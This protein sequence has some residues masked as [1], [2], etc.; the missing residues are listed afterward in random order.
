MTIWFTADL[1]LGHDNIIG[2]CNRPFKDVKEMNERLI[3]GWQSSVEEKDSIYVL[4]DISFMKYGETEPIIKDLPGKKYW[5]RGNHDSN[6]L[7][8]EIGHH[9][10]WI[11]DYWELKREGWRLILSHYKMEDWHG[12]PRGSLMLHGHSHGPN[13]YSGVE[14]RIDVGVDAWEYEPVSLPALK[15]YATLRQRMGKVDAVH[16]ENT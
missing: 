4:G 1:H 6:R 15:T 14:N 5:I 12:C 11:N 10:K 3:E 7:V 13:P 8:D 2:Y 9:F 16:R